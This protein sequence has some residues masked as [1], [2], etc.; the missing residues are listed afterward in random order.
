[1]KS[2]VKI[3]NTK[4]CETTV[5]NE[6]IEKDAAVNHVIRSEYLVERLFNTPD[7]NLFNHVKFNLINDKLN[8]YINGN[9][10]ILDIGCG[11]QV[12]KRYLA[13]FNS[14]LQYKGADYEASFEPDYVVDLNQT[15]ALA[16]AMKWQPQVVM[17][18]DVLEHLHDNTKDLGDVIAHIAE[19]V[20]ADS[21]LI[22]TLPQWYRLDCFKPSHLYY[23]EHKIRLNQREWRELIE[24]HFDIVKTQGLGYLSVIP[25]LP[26][27]FKNYKNDN[28]LGAFYLHLRGKIMEWRIFKPIDLFLSRTIGK[29][30]G[31][32]KLSN[33]I[34]FVAKPLAT[35]AVKVEK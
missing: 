21:V 10:R 30:P 15:D 26:M 12:S 25:Y 14:D 16:D 29:L 4:S 9:P 34:L 11:L 33:D 32:N 22:I 3:T 17:L 18:L 6:I 13:S 35:P 5:L 28:W 24:Q 7:Y 20:P 1:M 27:A 23:P 8:K 31:F 2:S 19:Q